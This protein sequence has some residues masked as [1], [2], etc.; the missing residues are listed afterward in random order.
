MILAI[1]ASQ[2]SDVACFLMDHD[3]SNLLVEK[4]GGITRKDFEQMMQKAA[5]TSSSVYIAYNRRF[6][7]SV[8]QAE[9]I[10]E[11]DGGVQSFHFEFTEWPHTVLKSGLPQ[12]TIDKWLLCNSSHIIDLAFYLGGLPREYASFTGGNAPWTK[13]KIRYSGAGVSEH[14]ALF[15]YFAN[16]DAPGRWKVEMMTRKHRLIFWPIEKLQIQELKTVKIEP[17]TRGD[18]TLDTEYKP[19]LYREVAAFLKLRDFGSHRLKT[20]EEQLEML[21]HFEKIAGHKY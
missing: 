16:W 6:Y 11:E 19:G 18:Y 9:R 21:T 3:V 10:I 14:G 13:E 12:E 15:D 5:E 17:D 1:D 2:L 8:M 4:P 7:E 20:A